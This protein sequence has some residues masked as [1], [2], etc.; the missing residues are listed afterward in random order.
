MD[1]GIQES[2]HSSSVHPIIIRCLL[3]LLLAL[4]DPTKNQYQS[5]AMFHST[6]L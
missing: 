3:V 2:T 4:A 6:L 1:S 5:T